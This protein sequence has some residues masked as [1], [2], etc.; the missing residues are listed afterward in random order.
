VGYHLPILLVRNICISPRTICGSKLK[1]KSMKNNI[2]LILS[3]CIQGNGGKCVCAWERVRECVFCTPCLLIFTRLYP[4]RLYS[5]C[6]V[7]FSLAHHS[8]G[9]TQYLLHVWVFF[10]SFSSYLKNVRT[11]QQ[12]LLQYNVIIWALCILYGASKIYVVIHFVRRLTRGCGDSFFLQRT[13]ILYYYYFSNR[14]SLMVNSVL[15]KMYRSRL[16]T[17]SLIFDARWKLPF[18]VQFV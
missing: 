2:N 18:S 13:Y 15:K 6:Q 16:R 17:E 9:V 3:W 4:E 8:T 10:R 1:T 12:T 5:D 14:F 11:R 7:S